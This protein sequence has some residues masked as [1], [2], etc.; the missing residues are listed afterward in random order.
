MTT[1]IL[2]HSEPT[3]WVKNLFIQYF[4]KI[5]SNKMLKQVQHDILLSP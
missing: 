2:R 3:K 1:D 4:A 5:I